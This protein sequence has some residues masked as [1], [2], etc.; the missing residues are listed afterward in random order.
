MRR[1]KAK[2]P[3]LVI[4]G[5]VALVVGAVVG[6]LIGTRATCGTNCAFNVDLFEAIGTWVG[7]VALALAALA[8]TIYQTWVAHRNGKERALGIATMCVLRAQPVVSG[9][10]LVRVEYIFRNNTGHAVHNVSAHVIDGVTLQTDA[11]V[12]PGRTWG[13]KTKPEVVGLPATVSCDREAHQLVSA[14][15]RPRLVF[16]FSVDGFRFVRNGKTTYPFDEAPKW[17]SPVPTDD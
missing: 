8:F 12:E 13:F 7:G 5:A 15:V 16:T 3:E 17:R 6:Y 2:A 1:W 9:G 4:V 10:R 11:R 14:Q